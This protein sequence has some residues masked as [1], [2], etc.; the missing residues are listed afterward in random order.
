MRVVRLR[1]RLGLHRWARYRETDASPANPARAAEWHVRCGDCGAE[2]HA[3]TATSL[4]IFAVV[5]AG[6]VLSLAFWSPLVGALLLVGAMGGLMW[7]MGPA[8]IG[9]VVRWLSVGR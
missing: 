2:R 9:F 1:C 6:G 4:M 3:G 8:A 5:F 7:A